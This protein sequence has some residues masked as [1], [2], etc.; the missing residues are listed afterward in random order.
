MRSF[1]NEITV[2][3]ADFVNTVSGVQRSTPPQESVQESRVVNNSFGAE[4]GRALGGIV[5]IVTKTGTNDFHGSAWAVVR[6]SAADSS[7]TSCADRYPR[8]S[9]LP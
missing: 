1:S 6:R 4:Y 2:H 7:P 5:N 3:G 8:F 9:Y